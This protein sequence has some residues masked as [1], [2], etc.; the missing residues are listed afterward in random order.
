[1]IN[2]RDERKRLASR[3]Q[4][5]PDKDSF[6]QGSRSSAKQ[7]SIELSFSINDRRTSKL[8]VLSFLLHGLLGL[9]L[10]AFDG[11]ASK[12]WRQ[13]GADASAPS[14][15]EVEMLA[16]S[17]KL[18]PQPQRREAV[19]TLEA[20]PSAQNETVHFYLPPFVC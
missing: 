17:S 6:A 18:I 4:N 11:L 7:P 5:A 8:M 16:N 20:S 13:L 1:M 10:F 12:P 15:I 3:F 9:G 19:Q 14:I 2:A